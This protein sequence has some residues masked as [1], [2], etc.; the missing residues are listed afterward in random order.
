MQCNSILVYNKP[1]KLNLRLSRNQP[2]VNAVY[3]TAPIKIWD[4]EATYRL[5]SQ[6]F[7]AISKSSAVFRKTPKENHV[8]V[9]VIETHVNCPPRSFGRSFDNSGVHR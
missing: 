7:N 9:R 1:G 5:L 6:F 4:T 3:Q 8:I 2:S